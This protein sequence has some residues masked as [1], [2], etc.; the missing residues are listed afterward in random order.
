MLAFPLASSRQLTT[1]EDNE[2]DDLF[3]TLQQASDIESLCAEFQDLTPSSIP[4][5]TPV[6]KPPAN[7]NHGAE[8]KL[9][10]IMDARIGQ[11]KCHSAHDSGLTHALASWVQIP[12]GHSKY[13]RHLRYKHAT[14]QFRKDS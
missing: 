1:E 13:Y 11:H 4:Q 8:T 14:S 3:K 10:W 5:G 7:S 2:I 12:W 9:S 6:G